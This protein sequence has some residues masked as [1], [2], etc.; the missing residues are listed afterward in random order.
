VQEK[1]PTSRIV[2]R[3]KGLLVLELSDNQDTIRSLLALKSA[4]R[5]YFH[6]DKFKARDFPKLFQKISKMPWHKWLSMLP[7]KITASTEESRL[8]HS[9]R[10]Q[11]TVAKGIS[12]AF[13]A[14]PVA[15]KWLERAQKFNPV[16]LKVRVFKDD[17]ELDLDLAGELHFKRGL[18]KKSGEAPLREN[19]AY[20]LL[21][22]IRLENADSTQLTLIDPMAGSGTLLLEAAYFETPVLSPDWSLWGMKE[23][24]KLTFPKTMPMPSPF[25]NLQ[26]IEQDSA[27]F[28]A[29]EENLGMIQPSVKLQL[30]DALKVSRLE[31]ISAETPLIAVTN[32]PYNL[33]LKGKS[34]IKL[35]DEMIKV[36]FEKWH[37]QQFYFLLPTQFDSD[38]KSA[39]KKTGEHKILLSFNHGGVRVS[40]H[41]V[42]AATFRARKS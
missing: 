8:L 37:C 5:I 3:E 41:Q 2:S 17:V 13:K 40:F 29:L 4:A 35:I 6:L 9:D 34:P 26:A 21:K 7:A 1:L 22:K 23:F 36:A 28:K 38:V 18:K 12:A 15:K 19:L 16:H 14:Q 25:V 32:P 11:E 33:R 10:I 30:A 31:N 42:I 27:Q 20:L 39:L 24:E